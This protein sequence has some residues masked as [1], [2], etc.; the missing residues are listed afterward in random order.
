MH[1]ALS[2]H[3]SLWTTKA[4]KRCVGGEVSLTDDAQAADI[5]DVVSIIQVKQSPF[6]NLVKG[7]Y[8]K[9]EGELFFNL[10]PTPDFALLTGARLRCSKGSCMK[11]A[12]L[13]YCQEHTI[14]PPGEWRGRGMATL[15]FFIG[16]Q[17]WLISDKGTC[18]IFSK[19]VATCILPLWTLRLQEGLWLLKHSP[20]KVP[21]GLV[22]S[23]AIPYFRLW[24]QATI[25][26]VVFSCFLKSVFLKS[27]A[28]SRFW[29]YYGRLY[30]R[31]EDNAVAEF[32]LE[33][34]QRAIFGNKDWAKF[35]CQLQ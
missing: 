1:P 34:A 18:C 25:Q 15:S 8:K 4:T 35:W 21:P 17:G 10:F 11:W 6:H 3:H 23:H 28:W 30:I 13:P 16:R 9:R 20:L 22:L 7:R 29:Q 27:P 19:A 24:L 14:T 32:M 31:L 26:W 33:I 5:R 12:A 2:N